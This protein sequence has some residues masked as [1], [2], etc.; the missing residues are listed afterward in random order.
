METVTRLR[1][2]GEILPPSTLYELITNETT[3][4]S[5]LLTAI[6]MMLENVSHFVF[7]LLG[8]TLANFIIDD[9]LLRKFYFKP[10]LSMQH[11]Q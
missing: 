8:G 3:E 4:S 1:N 9:F 2:N 10:Y 6:L 11:W 7:L 5:L